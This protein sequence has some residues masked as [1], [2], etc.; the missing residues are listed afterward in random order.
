ML[1]KNVTNS[2]VWLLLFIRLVLD[3]L[4]GVQFLFQGKWKHSLAIIKA[5]FSFYSLF[6]TYLKKRNKNTTQFKYYL[7]KSIV[8]NYFVRKNRTFKQLK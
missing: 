5:H 7:I 3:G 6:P 8:W 4:A 2:K 1:I